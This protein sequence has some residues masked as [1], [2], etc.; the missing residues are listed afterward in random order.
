MERFIFTVIREAELTS[1]TWDTIWKKFQWSMDVML[2]RSRLRKM[3]QVFAQGGKEVL[4][5]TRNNA[6]DNMCWLCTASTGIQELLY[7]GATNRVTFRTHESRAHEQCEQGEQVPVSMERSWLRWEHVMIDF[8]HC[9]DQ[10]VMSRV[11]ANALLRGPDE[12]WLHCLYLGSFKTR[13][14]T[15]KDE[16]GES[17]FFSCDPGSFRWNNDFTK[18]DELRDDSL[19]M[20]TIHLPRGSSTRPILFCRSWIGGRKKRTKKKEGK[21]S[22]S[23]LLILSTSMQTKQKLI[24]DIK[25]PRKVHY[26]IHWRPEQDAVYRIHLS[27]AQ[28]SGLE[29]WQTG[30]NAIITYQSVPKECVVKVVSESG[31]R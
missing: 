16:N 7:T 14:E 2:G 27:P 23:L 19:Q 26:Q 21:Q 20:E 8:L 13:F 24:T 11:A 4:K 12:D 5:V 15:C 6:N 9:V 17:R 18:T 10:A 30:S 28:D 1:A 22:S 3:G 25:K 29:F 31:K